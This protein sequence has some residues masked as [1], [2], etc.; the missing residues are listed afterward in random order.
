MKSQ[1]ALSSLVLVF[2]AVFSAVIVLTMGGIPQQ[3]SGADLIV[4][5][6]LQIFD[7]SDVFGGHITWVIKGTAAHELRALIGEKYGVSNI[8][9]S[10]ASR[11][12]KGNLEKVVENDLFNCGYLGFVRIQHSDPLH[13][14]TKGIINDV[15]DIAGLLGPV[16]STS[17]ITLKMLIRGEPVSGLHPAISRAIALAPFYALADFQSDI[18]KMNL[19][20]M[21]IDANLKAIVAG[22]GNFILPEGTLR[23]R[24]LLGEF[25]MAG[26]S[27]VGYESF[28][29]LSSPLILFVLYVAVAYGVGRI[30]YAL[31][32]DKTDTL[33]EKNARLY[34][35]G[36]RIAALFLYFFLPL[37]GVWLIVIYGVVF[38]LSYF[39]LKRIYR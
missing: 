7:V 34:V 12:F 23:A 17:T 9:I 33:M 16:N 8:D 22:T 29:L 20:N 36:I 11:Y 25:F 28:S 27:N 35:R 30:N 32:G 24:L 38:G 19:G 39:I 21:K 15:G 5:A 14:D 1:T 3:Q 13:G 18:E 2:F 10:V 31:V 4:N 6:D 26:G 37:S